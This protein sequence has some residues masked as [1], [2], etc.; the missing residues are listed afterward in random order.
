MRQHSIT[1]PRGLGPPRTL[2]PAAAFDSKRGVRSRRVAPS[3]G[4]VPPAG[5]E[6]AREHARQRSVV[7]NGDRRLAVGYR[8]SVRVVRRPTRNPRRCGR[9]ESTGGGVR[10]TLVTAHASQPLRGG[11]P[12]AAAPRMCASGG[13]HAP[14]ARARVHRTNAAKPRA[15]RRSPPAGPPGLRTRRRASPSCSSLSSAHLFLLGRCSTVGRFCFG[16][17]W[18]E[19]IMDSSRGTPLSATNRRGG[20]GS[21]AAETSSAANGR[22]RGEQHRQQSESDMRTPRGASTQGGAGASTSASGSGL[23]GIGSGAADTGG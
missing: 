9:A 6:H 10:R 7:A 5:W 16:P 2:A 20:G 13:G 22:S 17:F 19:A 8:H 11:P 18:A 21:S 12:L 23:N 1:Y 15:Q 14:P 4:E 3:A